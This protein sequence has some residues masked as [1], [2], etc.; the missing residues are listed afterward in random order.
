M[1]TVRPSFVWTKEKLRK[2]VSGFL[3]KDEGNYISRE[4]AISD[5][6]AGIKLFEAPLCG[7]ADPEDP[8]FLRAKQPDVIGPHCLLPHEWISEARTVVSF[9]LPFSARVREANTV[10]KQWPAEE[11][12]HG[13]IE[14][15]AFLEKLLAF[16]RDRLVSAGYA[17]TA[18]QLDERYRAGGSASIAHTA[19]PESRFTSNWSE[20]H[21]AFICGLCTFGLSR[22][23]ITA[24][25][26]AGRFGSIVTTLALE[27]SPR[28]YTDIYEYCSRCGACVRNC[29]ANAISLEKGK[30][31]PPCSR[32]LDR[33]REKNKPR[34]GCGKCQV[35][36]PCES[37]RPK[38]LPA[39][40]KIAL[41]LC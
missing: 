7:C 11:W 33:I 2:I 19:A 29:P 25:G 9:F 31:H 23:L 4:T 39:D 6:S 30:E 41:P 5:R 13:R 38:K 12:L 24:R 10:D 36:V 40:R 20:R 22:G 17:S 34:Y 3:E 18:P 8:L 35:N 27:P 15:Q 14:G 28:D 1:G 37:K 21:V 26:V 16:I 32:Y